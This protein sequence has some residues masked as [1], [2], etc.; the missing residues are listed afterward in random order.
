MARKRKLKPRPSASPILYCP[1]CGAARRGPSLLKHCTD[2][3]CGR[4]P[5]LLNVED[6]DYS[7]AI[8]RLS[9]KAIAR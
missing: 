4:V 5:L 6:A 9:D 2:K 7:R 1:E 8:A 3:H